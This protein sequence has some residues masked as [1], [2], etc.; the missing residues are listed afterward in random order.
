MAVNFTIK[1]EEEEEEEEEIV[2][3]FWNFQ[4]KKIPI[5]KNLIQ[6]HNFKKT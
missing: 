3:S 6:I 2:E 1:K 4:K 5:I